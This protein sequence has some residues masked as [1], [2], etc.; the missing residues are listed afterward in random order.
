MGIIRDRRCSEHLSFSYCDNPKFRSLTDM[1][2]SMMI[3]STTTNTG[4]RN[5]DEVYE[6]KRPESPMEFSNDKRIDRKNSPSKQSRNHAIR[7]SMVHYHPHPLQT[8]KKWICRMT[9][10][11]KRATP[12]L[13]QRVAGRTALSVNMISA[14]SS[15]SQ[16]RVENP[17]RLASKGRT[18]A[19]E[20]ENA[21]QTSIWN[22]EQRL[23]NA[24]TEWTNIFSRQRVSAPF[25]S[26]G[27]RP[28]ILTA[29]N[30]RSNKEWGD[31]LDCKDKSSS[32]LYSLNAN[33]LSLDK[34][35]GQFDEL[36]KIAKEVQADILRCQEHNL[37][38][39]QTF[40]KRTIFETV[41]QHRPRSRITMG[42]TSTCTGKR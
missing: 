2:A 38:I 32:R 41:R 18:V 16:G 4:K 11:S 20:P 13:Q 12:S 17:Y 21:E 37:D 40:V 25:N 26:H 6:H 39:M 36:C 29:Q 35:G 27:N 8:I 22:F 19:R 1:V 28:V 7:Q 15:T 3:L 42:T 10:H 9:A 33:G 30:Q 5:P 31:R 23:K 14:T 34:R 24:Q